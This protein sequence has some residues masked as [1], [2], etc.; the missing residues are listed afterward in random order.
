M[1]DYVGIFPHLKD[2]WRCIKEHIIQNKDDVCF[3]TNYAKGPNKAY[4]QLRFKSRKYYVHIIAAMKQ[5]G[6]P[7]LPGEEASHICH[8]P[9]CVNPA[10]LTF[11]TGEVNKTRGCCQ[12]FGRVANYR[13]PHAPVC[14]GCVS[15]CESIK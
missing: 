10:H 5:T 2:V 4:Q 11:E 12:V 8:N 9:S 14:L 3:S 1:A 13:C 15:I 6:R 7:P